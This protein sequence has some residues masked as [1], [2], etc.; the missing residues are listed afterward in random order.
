MDILTRPGHVLDYF[1]SKLIY[2]FDLDYQCRRP[3]STALVYFRAHLLSLLTTRDGIMF[4]CKS[5]ND[6]SGKLW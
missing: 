2:R 4:Q 1:P 5:L 3:T 6:H